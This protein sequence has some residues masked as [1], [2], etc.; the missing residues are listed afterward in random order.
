MNCYCSA[1]KLLS[2]DEIIVAYPRKILC[3]KPVARGTCCIN[4]YFV[5]PIFMDQRLEK[6]IHHFREIDIFL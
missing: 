3:K 1:E 4:S 6:A 5:S 2:S